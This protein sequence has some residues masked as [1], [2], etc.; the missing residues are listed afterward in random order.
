MI[1]FHYNDAKR[2]NSPYPGDK[3]R[4]CGTGPWQ[5]AKSKLQL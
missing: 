3:K 1:T 4:S 5:L 2:E